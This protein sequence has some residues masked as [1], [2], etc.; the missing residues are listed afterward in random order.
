[1]SNRLICCLPASVPDRGSYGF[2]TRSALLSRGE[3]SGV[4]LLLARHGNL[5]CQYE[6]SRKEEGQG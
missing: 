2:L 4:F 3:S 1:M 6:T 5:H